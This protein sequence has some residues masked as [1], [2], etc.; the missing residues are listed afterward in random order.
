MYITEENTSANAYD[1]KI[2]LDLLSFIKKVQIK[3]FNYY[4]ILTNLNA[5]CDMIIALHYFLKKCY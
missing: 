1:F 4:K 3:I 2:A 5:T